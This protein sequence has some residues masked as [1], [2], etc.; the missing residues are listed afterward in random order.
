[1]PNPESTPS[2][3]GNPTNGNDA[4]KS[5]L[6]KEEQY[7]WEF[8]KYQFDVRDKY[9]NFFVIILAALVGCFS[10][11]TKSKSELFIVMFSAFLIGIA[12]FFRVL[13]QRKMTTLSKKNLAGIREFLLAET[14]RDNEKKSD[15]KKISDNEIM[16][17]IKRMIN[18]TNRYEQKFLGGDKTVFGMIVFVIIVSGSICLNIAISL[19]SIAQFLKQISQ[20]Y[21]KNVLYSFLLIVT[22]T[23]I[24]IILKLI[25]SKL[26]SVCIKYSF[27]IL[28]IFIAILAFFISQPFDRLVNSEYFWNFFI[29]LLYLVTSIS[30]LI[31]YWHNFF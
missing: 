3:N 23:F 22:S 19:D 14:Y 20:E 15:N 5:F 9:V 11:M 12:T 27:L 4:L 26:L 13:F 29:I 1:M 18:Q 7:Y 25:T 21:Y 30:L 17:D 28:I 6:K 16:S 8:M 2:M 10:F 31:S 24:C